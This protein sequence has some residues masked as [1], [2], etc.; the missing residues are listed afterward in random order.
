[1]SSRTSSVKTYLLTHLLVFGV[2]VG[3]A[4]RTPRDAAIDLAKTTAA[5][6]LS[7]NLDTIQLVD[8]VEVTWRDSSLGCPEAGRVYTPMVTRGYRVTLRVLEAR[9]VI[10]TTT[11]RAVICRSSTIAAPNAAKRPPVDP[12]AGLRLADR[13]RTDLATRLRVSRD[14]VL[15]IFFRPMTWPDSSLG[16]PV[17]GQSYTQQLSKGFLIE[18]AYG[19][20]KYEYHADEKHLVDCTPGS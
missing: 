9:L 8:A 11:D 1:M 3:I 18:L 4:Q 13:A 7:V 12:S 17:K 16:C 6:E 10:N 5:R 15:V 2:A 19:G 20:K 14:Q